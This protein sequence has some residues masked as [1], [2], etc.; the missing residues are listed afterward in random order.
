MNGGEIQK[1]LHGRR[2]RSIAGSGGGGTFTRPRIWR[3]RLTMLG[4]SMLVLTG[5]YFS[6]FSSMA[7]IWWRSETFAHGFVILPISAYLIWRLRERL[8]SLSFVTD[9]R[10]VTVL[11]LLAGVWTLAK[12]AHVLVVQQ[13]AVVAMSQLQPAKPYEG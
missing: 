2:T 8:R 12:V 1:D 6:T 11:V 10:A 3:P 5:V 9:Y 13:L 7:Q 4:I